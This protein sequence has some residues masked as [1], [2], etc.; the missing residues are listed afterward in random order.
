MR[1]KPLAGFSFEPDTRNIPAY[2]G[3]TLGGWCYSRSRGEHPRVCGEN[4]CSSCIFVSL[5]GTSPRMRGKPCAAAIFTH[6]SA[7]HPRVCGENA[8]GVCIMKNV[9]GTS[10]RM[11]GK[12]PHGHSGLYQFRNIP[13][14]A[15]KTPACRQWRGFQEEHPR[16]CGE[17]WWKSGAR[18]FEPGTSPRMRGKRRAPLGTGRMLGNI[19]AYAGKT[20]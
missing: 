3:K 14:Y 9:R 7:E 12:P 11:R 1:G 17:N 4:P 10:P 18:R 19:P 5:A 2:A 15:G 13:A 20:D 16:V 8:G 6:S